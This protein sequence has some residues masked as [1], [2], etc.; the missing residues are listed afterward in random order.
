[1]NLEE[2]EKM[3]MCEEKA[4]SNSDIEEQLIGE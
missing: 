3:G 1:M 2:L 4:I